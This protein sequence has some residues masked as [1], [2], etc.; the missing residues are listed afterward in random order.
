[1]DSKNCWTSAISFVNSCGMRLEKMGKED[2]LQK[3]KKNSNKDEN[4]YRTQQEFFYYT[5]IVFPQQS[6]QHI[7]TWDPADINSK[8]NPNKLD[9]IAV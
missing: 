7:V 4:V 3:K 1:M 2:L 8:F 9:H 5:L 6:R